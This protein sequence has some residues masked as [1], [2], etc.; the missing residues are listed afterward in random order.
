[1]SRGHFAPLVNKSESSFKALRNISKKSPLW[2]V[3]NYN[4]PV[5]DVSLSLSNG[6][7]FIFVNP[8][9]KVVIKLLPSP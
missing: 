2:F 5:S 7:E 8:F 9:N 3:G 4:I 1:M 6:N